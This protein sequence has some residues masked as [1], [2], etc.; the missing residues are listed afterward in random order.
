MVETLLKPRALPEGDDR[1]GM[2]VFPAYFRP[3]RPELTE[4]PPA[5]VRYT[6]TGS[7]DEIYTT[8]VVRLHHTDVVRQGP[9]LRDAADFTT[10][11][12]ATP[13]RGAEAGAASR[14]L[15]EIT[16]FLDPKIPIEVKV[17]FM[18][19]VHDHLQRLRSRG[20]GPAHALL[21][22]PRVRATL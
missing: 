8:L 22:L 14:V 7:L 1:G 11:V 4:H 19:Y 12:T 2:L 16:V 15:G 13:P 21:L 20:G 17:I 3:D 5:Y 10:R 6:F 9:A 18:R